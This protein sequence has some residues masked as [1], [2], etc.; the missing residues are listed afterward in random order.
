[1]S[2]KE[3]SSHGS[4]V[5][6]DQQY[7]ARQ[8]EMQNGPAFTPDLFLSRLP[9]EG[10]TWSWEEGAGFLVQVILPESIPLQNLEACLL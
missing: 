5:V 6:D 2:A 1:M 8:T 3:S 10:A 4:D 9:L 7:N